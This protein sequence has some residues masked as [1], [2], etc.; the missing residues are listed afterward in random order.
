LVDKTDEVS[1]SSSGS[2]DYQSLRP[3]LPYEIELADNARTVLT[4]RYL[5][6]DENGEPT[7]TPEEMFWRVAWHVAEPEPGFAGDR[8]KVAEEFYYMLTSKRFFPNSPTFT[9]AGTPL[10]QLAACFVL[11]IDDDMGRTGQGIFETLRNAALIQQTGGGNGFAFSNLRPAGSVVKTSN[12]QA[13]GPI[14]FLKV[15]DQAFGEI[16]QGGCL[17]SDTLVFTENGLLRLDEIV[18]RTEPGWQS[19]TLTV[20]TDEGPRTSTETYN[21]GVVPTLRVKT[22]AGIEITGTPN[23]KVKVMTA[24]GPQWRMLE[25]LHPGEAIIVMLGQQQG[26]THELAQPEKQHG[27]QIMPS[28][29][30]TLNEELAF[31]LGYMSGDGFIASADSDHRIGVTVAHNSYLMEEMPNLLARLFGDHIS[32]HRLQKENDASVTFVI[33]NRAVKDFLLLN[34]FYKS[35][36]N[37]VQVPALIRQSAPEIV[38]AYLSGLFEAD[39]TL[40]HNY[41]ELLTSSETLARE[42]ATLLIGLGTPVRMGKQPVT[43]DRF[44][45]APMWRV[46]I[47]SFVGLDAWRTWIGCDARS[48]FAVCYDFDPDLT[49]EMS[50]PLPHAEYWVNPVLDAVTLPQ[51][52]RQGRGQGINFRASQPKLRKKLLRY[53]RGDRQLTM[54]AYER[55]SED[56]QVFADMA[57][58]VN[59][60]WFI[61]V[62]AVEDA[63][64]QLTL[65]LEVE[66]NHTY[67]ANG[68]V[69]HN[70][71]RGAN[72]GVLRVDHPDIYEF[73]RCKTSEDAI[74]NFNISVGIT[75]NFMQAVKDDTDFDLLNPQDGSVAKTVRARDLFDEIVEYAHFNGEPGMLFLDAANRDNPVPHLYQLEATNPCG[76]QWLGPF[77]NCCLGSINLGQH[78]TTD[79]T[80]DW[81]KLRATTELATHFLDD[82]VT[83]NAYVDAVPELRLAAERV[84]RIGLGIMGLGDMMYDLGVRYGS[85]DGIEFASQ[86]MEFIH[87]H[88]MKTSIEL[89][90]QRGSFLAITGSYY[91]PTD[92]KW[93][94]P[95]P[96]VPY[97]RDYGRPDVNWGHI[98]E[99]IKKFGIRN[100]AVTTCAPTGTISTVS[101]VEGYGCEPVFALAYV[102]Y[103]DDNGVRRQLQYTSPA[104]AK[105]LEDAGIEGEELDRIIEEVNHKGSI[106]DVEG[107]PD[108]IKHTF[109]VASDI[110]PEEH[111]R[112]QA[113]LQ[114]FVSN[115]ISKTCN[116]PSTATREDVAKV[117]MQG[118][119]LGCKGMTVY[120][121]GS[122]DKVVLETAE[123]RETKKAGDMSTLEDDTSA[124]DKIV[125]EEKPTTNGNGNPGGSN[126]RPPQPARDPEVKAAP[127]PLFTS[128]T[129]RP[130]SR[131]LKGYTYRSR[132]P[133][134]TTF[135]T[136]NENGGDQPFE[137]FI[138]TSKAGS[139]TAAVSE[140][141]GRLI[142]YILRM[143]SPI[144]PRARLKELATQLDGIGGGRP[145]GLGPNRVRSLPDGVAQ[146]LAEYLQDSLEDQQ[147]IEHDHESE[148]PAEQEPSGPTPG[149]MAM[150]I[151]DLCPECGQA[152]VVNEE[153]C[154]KCY[155]CGYSEC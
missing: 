101:G 41:P 137:V 127:L 66:G 56:Y 120:V 19:H 13:T 113:A 84:R 20:A 146:I 152:A 24:E 135:I 130:R 155:A 58:Q 21:N 34:G 145:L 38:G 123:T 67:L 8:Q 45:S 129:K 80:V 63:G 126:P 131:R 59:N 138:H 111:V 140:A 115:A 72:M 46:R 16:A 49:R 40:S 116:F 94:E 15:Y 6:K 89:A 9:G 109:V 110:S 102:R 100:G 150:A 22:D 83:A 10:G 33:D 44:G 62:E 29:P 47:N 143:N 74:T 144:E 112:M 7:E 26:Q 106:Q 141:I 103:F 99:G 69:T 43:D 147:G 85:E 149:Q 81:E 39:G 77:E 31:F 139:E 122:R 93:Q 108:H 57:V 37:D 35:G 48:R 68:L 4:K 79:G 151:G 125:E 64:E 70:T 118:W 71:R 65:D 132:T 92:L 98:T 18:T 32:I 87:Y 54:S 133:L 97:I 52:D 61:S 95:E 114:R 91:D 82:V 154:R 128:E 90:K 2:F 107:V 17:T 78:V 3:D 142:S 25:D 11:Q 60:R 51:I 23:H 28:L 1:A 76:E 27:N 121:A 30:T 134:G 88:S 5:R 124:A 119:E 73:I 86:V 50:Y 104:L 75:D 136:I 148:F 14:G 105:A 42:V 117:F 12:G 153:G 55:L 96:M 53:V 36:S